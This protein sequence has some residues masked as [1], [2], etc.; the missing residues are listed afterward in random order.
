MPLGVDQLGDE[1]PLTQSKGLRLIG[2]LYS[3]SFSGRRSVSIQMTLSRVLLSS[4][5]LLFAC[6]TPIT[7]GS[8]GGGGETGGG[9]AD[10]GVGGGGG[11]TGGGA[12][13]GETGGG[14]GGGATG[15]GAT[16]GG[17][18]GGDDA[19]TILPDLGW[20][21]IGVPG[22]QCALGAQAGIG[23]HPGATDELAIFLQGGGACWNN[24]TCH[25][26]VYRW[27]PVCNYGQDSICAWDQP[28]GTQPLAVQVAH[29]NPYPAD[30]GGAFPGDLATIKSSLL[31]ARRLENPL[32]NASYVFVPYCTG[33]LHSGN[34]TR[35][36]HVKGGLFD[37][38]VPVVHHFAGGT[39]MDLYLAQLRTQHASVRTIWLMGV[40]GGGYGASLNLKRVRAAFPEAEV[41]L[42]ADSAPMV[43]TGYFDDWQTEWNMQLP[44]T[45]TGCDGGFPEVIQYMIDDE[46]TA[47]VALLATSEDQV[48]T[49]FMYSGG[50]FNSWLNPPY[51]TYTAN[52]VA[53][54]DRYDATPNAKYFRLPG[55]EHV[56]I[57]RYGLV[58]SDGGISPPVS[59]RDGGTDL[60]TWIDAWAT[61]GSPWQSHK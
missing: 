27:G 2:L 26:S 13:G 31:F 6:G 44:A 20:R 10:S 35:T 43:E 61:G 9:D 36:Y 7:T 16:G 32:R 52:L 34:S 4:L 58:L 14:M 17:T 12:G 60:K 18:G 55:Q 40:S 23:Y 46:P 24:G 54:E 49:R 51:S 38:V 33:D 1:E 42:L 47:R 28:G 29:P 21:F 5:V 59:S 15:G 57:Q 56:M 39:N 37:P 48:I 25:P 11:A 22:S 45:C 53:I 19:G 30:G 41:H 8:G 3:F 50:S